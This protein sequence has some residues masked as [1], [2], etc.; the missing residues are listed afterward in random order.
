[1]SGRRL[2][3]LG[4]L[5]AAVLAIAPSADAG[6]FWPRKAAPEK[7]GDAAPPSPAAGNGKAEALRPDTADPVVLRV[8]DRGSHYEVIAENRLPGPVQVQLSLAR[9][10][11][12][13]PVPALPASAVVPATATRVLARIYPL[14]PRL[15]EG[16]DVR[17]LQVPGD[18]Q[19]RPF[20]FQYRVPFESGHVRVDQ[21]FGGR[22]SHNDAQ[23]L[24]AVD[25]ALPEGTPVLAARDGVVLQVAS[26]FGQAGTGRGRP[27]D[28]ANYIRI[29]HDDGSMA[30]YGH[31]EREGVQVRVGQQVRQ[32]QRIALS[33]NTGYST[34][35]HLHFVVQ[36]NR[37]M[38]LE[39]IRF[40]M[41]SPAGELKFPRD[42]DDGR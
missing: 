9:A 14:D 27:G 12:V 3:R 34:G 25:F 20:D 35:P 23:N 5:A 31:L 26:D 10:D 40:R 21:G 6:P 22:F 39:A 17:L 11:N 30:V 37:G 15:P 2:R 32:G 18:P 8:Q 16:I 33:G 24:Y 4:W 41:F 36:A 42:A 29:L 13:R 7:P 1:M 19:A 28:G 38:R